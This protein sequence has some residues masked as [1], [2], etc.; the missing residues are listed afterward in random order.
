MITSCNVTVLVLAFEYH[1]LLLSTTEIEIYV[2][3]P[4]KLCANVI[5]E[6][7]FLLFHTVEVKVYAKVTFSVWKS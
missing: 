3:A 2:R 1:F 7:Y 6:K 4:F 5:F